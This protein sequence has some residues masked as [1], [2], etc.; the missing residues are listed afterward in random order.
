MS[1]AD[2]PPTTWFAADSKHVSA[3]AAAKF[4]GGA[5]TPFSVVE[6]CD[7]QIIKSSVWNGVLRV[8]A[9]SLRE[10]A[11]RLP[12]FEKGKPL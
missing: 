12:G 6:L 2:T 10:Y 7:A 5:F 9:K 1:I 3:R 8:N 11:E 4:L